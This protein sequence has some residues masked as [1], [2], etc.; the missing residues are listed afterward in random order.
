MNN[1]IKE[2]QAKGSI[3]FAVRARPN[4]PETKL[5]EVMD[6][7]SLKI[8]IKAPAEDGKANAELIKFLAKEFGVPQANVKIV[9]G[10]TSRHKL[11]AIHF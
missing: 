8:A 11:V 7:E 10:T 3:R 1:F 9:G 4:A 6:D 2:L 5:L